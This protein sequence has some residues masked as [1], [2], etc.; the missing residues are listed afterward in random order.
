MATEYESRCHLTYLAFSPSALTIWQRG[1]NLIFSSFFLTLSPLFL[2]LYHL[3][4]VPPT[5]FVLFHY[6]MAPSNKVS[7]YLCQLEYGRQSNSPPYL[8]PE[9]EIE[10][11]TL[12]F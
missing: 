5:T 1:S 12:G 9:G 2:S 7:F 4:E 10:F 6:P 3:F 11:L 8:E